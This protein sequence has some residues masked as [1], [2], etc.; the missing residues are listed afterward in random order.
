MFMNRKNSTGLKTQTV[1]VG[2]YVTR[3]IDIVLFKMILYKNYLRNAFPVA[4]NIFFR[5]TYNVLF[6]DEKDPV[7]QPR[8]HFRGEATSRD[9]W[10]R[11]KTDKVIFYC[12][13]YF[14][15]FTIRNV[16]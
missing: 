14:R 16:K 4:S 6:Q 13:N 1:K 5:L 15:S 8:K 12:V 3:Q 2:M 7:P 10:K 9:N 11:M